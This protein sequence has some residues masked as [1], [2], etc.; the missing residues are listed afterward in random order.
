MYSPSIQKLIEQFSKLPTVGPRTAARFA[1]Y[2]IG[3]SKSETEDL[4]GAILNVKRN[5]KS[6]R[7]CF[8]V[9]ESEKEICGICSDA[10]RDNEVICVVANETD[11]A[12]IEKIKTYKG[13]YFV[14]GAS[15]SGFH[16]QSFDSVRMAELEKRVNQNKALK[17]IVLAINPTPDGQ[18]AILYLER[19]LKPFGL[20]I[21]KLG[22]GL[23]F[24]GELEY[25]D[26]ETLSS[27]LIGRK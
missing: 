13:R 14:L 7:I 22:L 15:L 16:R 9:Y 24:G 5:V 4:A 26:E 2:L 23:P 20:K 11:L 10:R 3:R 18:A 6:C 8:N 27:A 21:T 1:F 25:A 19:I 12:T 17:E